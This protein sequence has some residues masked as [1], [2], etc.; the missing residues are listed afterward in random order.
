MI[1]YQSAEDALKYVKSNE[2]IFIHGG[3]ATPVV[4][5][6]ALTQRHEELKQVEIV[7]LHTEGEPTYAKPEYRN[8]FFVNSFF[9]GGNLREFVDH[10]N[11][12]YVP[13]F[14]SE[15]PSLFRKGAMPID[16]ALIQ[17]SPPD[18]HG[19]CSLGISIDVAKAATDV[20]KKIIALVNPNMP[21][22]HGDGQIHYTRFTAAVYTEDKIFEVQETEATETE[23]AIGKNCASIVEDGATLQL[24][25]GGI[26]NAVL[27]SLANH[28]DLGIHT[29]MFS[30]G[31]LPL[32]EK[33]IINGR[34][35]KKHP[36]KIV[37]GFA[38][39]TRKLYDFIHDNPMVAML[40]I[41]YVNDTSVI[42]KN[43]KVTAINGAVEIDLT[44]QV[45]SDS[46]GHH[47]ISG[48]GGQM[49]F[50]RGASLSEGGKPIIAISS[51][52]T[53]GISKI[54]PFLKPGAGVVTTRAHVHYVVT[55]FGIANL[56]GK[57]ISQRA[58]ALINIAHP[59]HR[60][61]LEK[62]A[63]ELYG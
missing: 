49:D 30:N 13:V 19:F 15:I 58:K 41:A 53:K 57:N 46:I 28:K 11:V 5:V 12:Q 16:I 40:D 34:F 63:F 39:G 43:D 3:A 60:A 36:G 35:K 54:V 23:I 6:T 7:H 59:D 14:L 4:L 18:Q 62:K 38:M 42:R 56:Y 26:P 52:T 21:R 51:T 10:T 48:V 50:I 33:G 9:I 47:I 25:I 29:E 44:G 22:S 24:G 20:A 31:I 1:N 17:V 32:V 45:C 61:D 55:E 2:R 37:S 27:Q 8:S